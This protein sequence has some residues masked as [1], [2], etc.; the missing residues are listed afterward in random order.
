MDIGPPLRDCTRQQR[1]MY[2]KCR[3]P[4]KLNLI[5][6]FDDLDHF[7][8]TC[9]Y[10]ADGNFQACVDKTPCTPQPAHQAFNDTMSYV[11]STEQTR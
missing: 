1:D 6:I 2:Y 4:I 9:S 7:N 11:C 10:F 8:Q 5:A 3:N